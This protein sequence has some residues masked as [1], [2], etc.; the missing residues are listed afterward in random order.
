MLLSS[1]INKILLFPY[2]I[3][4]YFRNYFYDK[5]IF[6]SVKYD[7]PIIGVGNITVGGTGKT[8]HIEYLVRGL[9]SKYKI[10][11]ISRGYGRR[12]RGF[13][14]VE[15]ENTP[16]ECGD[17]SVQIK[18]KF[19]DII[20]AVDE[21]RRR[22]IET[23]LKLPFGDRPTLILLDDSYQ[24]R[25]VTPHINILLIDYFNPIFK[26]Y[27]LPFGRLRDLPSQKSR[28]DFTIITKC[29]GELDLEEQREFR[30]NEE[31]SPNVNMFYSTIEYSAPEPVYKDAD[32]RY[33]YSKFALIVTAIANPTPLYYFVR[34]KHT[35]NGRLDFRDHK[36]FTKMDVSSINKLSSKHPKCVIYTTEKDAQRFSK[37]NTLSEDVKK[38]L[39]YL[40]IEVNVKAENNQKSLMD[41]IEDKLQNNNI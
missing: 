29:P 33:S 20:V 32:R 36:N 23:L 41:A 11:V 9:I 40:P 7:I 4:L 13:K 14:Y 37:L 27:L 16:L 26:D 17:E 21:N 28:A 18:R 22:G 19:P 3:T 6:K 35:I 25:A 30:I 2:Y 38:R 12:T 5:G 8:P 10:A 15:T 34:S 31:I 1:F 39:F 24:H